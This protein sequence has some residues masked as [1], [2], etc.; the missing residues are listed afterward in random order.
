M[1]CD[2]K[3]LM[4]DSDGRLAETVRHFRVAR[5]VGGSSLLGGETLRALTDGCDGWLPDGL[6]PN[7]P[8]PRGAEIRAGTEG[9]G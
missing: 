6:E 4:T 2:H 5:V 8:A 1:P 9:D 7:S 3:M